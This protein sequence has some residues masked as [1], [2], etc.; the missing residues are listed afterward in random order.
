MVSAVFPLGSFF[1]TF[2]R[3]NQHLLATYATLN[4]DLIWVVVKVY[5]GEKKKSEVT[6]DGEKERGSPR[7]CRWCN[8]GAVIGALVGARWI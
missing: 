1:A 8:W 7:C 3:K 4:Y 6:T 2:Q 5:G